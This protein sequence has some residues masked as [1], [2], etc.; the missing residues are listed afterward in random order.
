MPPK[1][2]KGNAPAAVTAE[3]SSANPNK[4]IERNKQMDSKAQSQNTLPLMVDGVAITQDEEGRYS[5]N[6]LQ[7]AAVA[8]GVTKDI[9]PSEWLALQQ[10]QELIEVLIVEN[11]TIKPIVKTPGRYG[12]TFAAWELVY[13]YGMWVDA[14]VN[15]K[16]IRGFHTAMRTGTYSVNKPV[17]LDRKIQR[18]ESIARKIDKAQDPFSRALL[19]IAADLATAAVGLSMPD[20]SLLRPLQMPLDLKGGAA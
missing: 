20:I 18:I 8:A 17:P 15:L 9:R 14:Q 7:R 12:G 2:T 4:P 1:P 19:V 10:T 3:A 13:S 5:L 11:P 6:D 16:V